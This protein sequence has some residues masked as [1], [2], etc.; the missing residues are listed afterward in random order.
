MKK[1]KTFNKLLS[2]LVTCI[3]TFT[4]INFP[5]IKTKA[6]ES[7]TIAADS[8]A[9]L[10]GD[11]LNIQGLG[12][13]W[14]PDKHEIVMREFSNGVYYVDIDFKTTGSFNYKIAMNSSWD[15]SYGKDGVRNGE[16][17][18]IKVDKAEKI[19][20]LFDYKNKKIYDSVNNSDYFKKSSTLVGSFAQNGGSDWNPADSNYDLEY[21]GDG[22]YKKEF[23][24]KAGSYEYKV[25]YNHAWSN[26]EI[27]SNIAFKLD[28]DSKVTVLANPYLNLCLDSINNP[29]ILNIYS[30]LGDVRDKDSWDAAAKGYE[31]QNIG[32][33]KLVY[34]KFLVAKE[35]N[36]KACMNYSLDNWALPQGS[37]TSLKLDTDKY[38][39]FVIDLSQNK[40]FDSVN[41]P[42]EVAEALGLKKVPIITS[43]PVINANGTVTFNYKDT[44]AENVYLAGSMTDWGNGKKLMTKDSQGVWSITL[45][46]GDEEKD[47]EYK[48]IVGDKWVTDPLNNNV[49]NGNSIFHFNQYS[50]RKVV[51]AGSIQSVVGETNW[52][53]SSEKT[54]MNYKGNGL[55]E[56]IIKNVPA[57]KYE[58]KIA[59]GAW[60]PENYGLNGKSYGENIPLVV[61]K[62]QD[63][64]I[65]YNDDSHI[66][67]DSIS[68]KSIDAT[69]KGTGIEETKL[70]DSGLTGIYSAK[71]SFKKGIYGDLVLEIRDENG[72]LTKTVKVPM[73]EIKDDIK[74]VTMS[75]D[76]VSEMVFNDASSEKINTN[77]IYFN[78]KELEYKKPFGAIKAGEEVTFNLKSTKDEIK[79][80]KM[81][82]SSSSAT[83]VYDM[84]KTEGF[85]DKSDKWTLKQTFNEIGTYKYYFIVSNGSDI[86]AYGD[87]DGFFGAGKGDEL[88][89]VKS[90]EFNIYKPDFKTPDWMKNAVVY[91][92][93]P[94]RFFNG[95]K[96][97]D[98]L[99]KYARGTA[100]YEFYNN[101]YSIPENPNLEYEK[102]DNGNFVLD[103][104]GKPIIKAGYTGTV[105]DAYK[106]IWCNEMYGGDLSGIKQKLNYIQSLGVTV[107]YINPVSKSISNHRYDT[108]D[109]SEVDPLLGYMDDFVSLSKEAKSRGMHII[110]DG[111]YNHVSDDSVYFDRYGKYM[112]KNKPL[113]AYQ[114]WSKVYDLMNIKGLSQQEA[115]KEV[116]ADLAAQG[117][118]DLHYKDWF[119]IDN[120]KVNQGKS[121]EHY[122]YEGWWGYDS[123]PVIQALNGSEYNV[124]SWANE[125]IDGKDS[126]TRY[127]L[128]EGSSGWRLDV[129]NEVSDE[130][131]RNF[132]TAVKQEGDNAII[133]E[134]WTDASKYLL[135]DMY[136][137]VMNYRFR[138][139]VLGYLRDNKPA[140]EVMN[141]LELIR[142]QYPEEAF[143]AML[144]LVDSHDTERIL[145]SLDG[146][147]KD[148]NDAIIAG[149]PTE[150][151][152]KLQQ[153]V[154]LIQ[155]TYAGAPCIYYGDEAGMV[156]AKDP[157]NRRAMIWGKG[158]K[159]TV[160]NYAK[161]TSVRNNYPV[162]RTGEVSPA[163]VVGSEDV[164]S[165]ERYLNSSKAL[166]AINR[167]EKATT[168][169]IYVSNIKNGTVLKDALTGK[170]YTVEQGKISLKLEATSGVVLVNNY[171]KLNVNLN[172]VKDA[173]DPNYI[174][175]NTTAPKTDEQV[176]NEIKEAAKK[177]QKEVVVSDIL[178]EIST[179]VINACKENNIK[180]VINRGDTTLI[181]QDSGKLLQAVKDSGTTGLTLDVNDDILNS[182]AAKKLKYKYWPKLFK[183]LTINS[184]IINGNFNS[185]VKVNVKIDSR[186]DNEKLYIYN[187]DNKEKV[188]LV[189]ASLCNNGSIRFV[190]NHDGNYIITNKDLTKKHWWDWFHW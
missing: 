99:Q 151:A 94:D 57:G 45:R 108:T 82:I 135:G 86:K 66:A 160:Q 90:Y 174:V 185:Q 145:T 157:D 89:K 176:V 29:E 148:K 36:Y 114:Y 5:S 154:A 142:E 115:E 150:K 186:Y 188:S 181:M 140:S 178:E 130:T 161:L 156:G 74:V 124:K 116:T 107:L 129:A 106:D 59:M 35:Y 128:R 63:V 43:S 158:D 117:I 2:W 42:D 143:Y 15:E 123:M 81:V 170:C 137:S 1:R 38:V 37:N 62:A 71:I 177:G 98:Y 119:K 152:R 91:Q 14:A 48:F 16:N 183:G 139:A 75:Y 175:K 49:S 147:V 190:I 61:D 53:P 110:L 12:S 6:E 100:P 132:R 68:Y 146:I 47:Y 92:I 56:L 3:F 133:G 8:M 11:F 51:V 169:D 182:N 21:V 93:F 167:S 23:D 168:T 173:Y 179:V 121:S 96:N 180:P 165:Y 189:Q 13:D 32:G 54:R 27:G 101:W 149:D 118:T 64:T 76:P 144:N 10:T 126:N 138:E 159:Q 19:S 103:K 67:V 60:D 40:I 52:T 84:N 4:L 20:F 7:T 17:I 153:L 171:K 162:L 33:S 127:W 72:A 166:V 97:N 65:L 105:G 125:I 111:V 41:N 131:W 44:L 69:L 70:T 25:A 155:M 58:Y 112:A 22:F 78:S 164:L 85:D 39:V 141:Q 31:F 172:G 73:L 55:Y 46:L 50:G 88:G 9:I 122:Q 26:G 184:N 18:P 77:G 187:I 79:Q 83:K 30:I 136:D 28:K 80:A 109:Y 87:D 95:D 102:D 34:S 134:I 163:K 120:V 24:L 113:G 104:D